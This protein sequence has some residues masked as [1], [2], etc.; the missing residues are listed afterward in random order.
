MRRNRTRY[1]EKSKEGNDQGSRQEN[2]PMLRHVRLTA[3]DAL[4]KPIGNRPESYRRSMKHVG[5]S[6]AAKEMT[7]SPIPARVVDSFEVG[8]STSIFYMEL[9]QAR[10]TMSGNARTKSL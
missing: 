8:R 5:N 3:T 1:Y 6:K 2:V 9:G 7:F 10:P 4:R